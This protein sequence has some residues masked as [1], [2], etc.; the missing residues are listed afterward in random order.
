MNWRRFF[1]PFFQ[2]LRP[3]SVWQVELTTRCPLNC[4]MCPREGNDN[5]RSGDMDFREFTKLAPFF[6]DVDAVVLEGWGESLLHKNLIDAVKLVK[7]EGAR[8]GFVTSG[9]GLDKN[10]ARKLVA[11]GVDFIGFSLAGATRQTHNA[12]RVN[13]DLTVILNNI[14]TVNEVKAENQ[15]D[16]PQLHL[17]Y[18]MLRDNINETPHLPE[19]ARQVGVG[20][21]VLTNLIQ[22]TN[23]WQE[24]Q[25][26]FCC[27]RK[28][29]ENFSTIIKKTE[30]KAHELNVTLRTPALTPRETAVC[31]ENPLGN[32]YVATDGEVSPCVYLNPPVSSPFPRIFCGERQWQ[33]KVSFGNIFREPFNQIWNSAAYTEFREHFL[34]RK[35]GLDAMNNRLQ[36]KAGPISFRPESLP[37]FPPP[38]RH[39]HKSLGL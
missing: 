16:L 29:D 18:L 9:M 21:V 38:C 39:C 17:I 25:G 4:L 24:S 30:I 28:A 7:A 1:R 33:Q 15:T 19:L 34:R 20:T 12:I 27:S 26:V 36:N 22:M 35:Q 23:Q 3:F 13:S 5:W 31:D 11:A 8:A 37:E 2:P 32:L 14:E 6:R 10:Y